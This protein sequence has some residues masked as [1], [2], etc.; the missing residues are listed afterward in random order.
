MIFQR[1]YRQHRRKSGRSH[2][3][4]QAGIKSFGQRHQPVAPHIRLLRIAAPMRLSDAPAGQNH[5]VTG[6]VARVQRGLDRSRHIDAGHMRIL[7]DQ[8]AARTDAQSVLVVHRGILNRDRDLTL[9]Q[10]TQVKLLHSSACLAGFIV[11]LNHQRIEHI[12]SP[13][14]SGPPSRNAPFSSLVS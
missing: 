9:G 10:V 6:L 3:H 4:C 14:H 8:P 2:G 11:L 7:A 13:D 5:L 1:H 12:I